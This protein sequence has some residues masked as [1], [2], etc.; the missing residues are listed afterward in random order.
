MT[1]WFE[2]V[3]LDE[4]FPLGSHTFTEAEIIRFGGL[5]DPQYFHTDPNLA[6]HS[7]F[8]GLIASGWHTVSV[9]HRKMVDALFAEEER[10]R[11]LGQEP[12]VSGPSPG[13]NAMDFKAPVRP[14]DTV[15][16]QLIVTGKRRS[17]T[18]PGWGLLF[19]RLTAINQRGE[20]VYSADLVGFSKLRDYRMP[21]RLRVLLALTKVPVLGK[22][23]RRGS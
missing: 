3:T 22:L 4:A 21:A 17:N 1:R 7:H 8:G 9:G 2:D 16:Y 18:I 5:Y 6:K 20:L 19:N 15:T 10:L 13:V 14:G 11:A 23:I 12:G